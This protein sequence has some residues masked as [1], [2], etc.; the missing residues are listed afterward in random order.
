MI[1]LDKK[2]L[3]LNNIS[4]VKHFT[5]KF[6][7]DD[8][9]LDYDLLMSKGITALFN[10]VDEYNERNGIKFSTFASNRI[11]LE[12]LNEIRRTSSFSQDD[13]L[14]I[15]NF[16]DEFL[17]NFYKNYSDNEH[18]DSYTK[19]FILD[20]KLKNKC[21]LAYTAFLDDFLFDSEDISIHDLI[22]NSNEY[23][24]LLSRL[25]K[26]VLYLFYKEELNYNQISVVLN[27]ST[28]HIFLI[29]TIG[30]SKIR[31]FINKK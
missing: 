30:L 15:K 2:E 11:K 27:I 9:S 5:S 22:N 26:Y 25:E 1:S 4:I 31:E 3:I 16:C 24:N 8:F 21:L 14:Y 10:C 28:N 13:V 29:H 20:K 18:S 7:I 19:N 17:S 6:Y 23:F 12:I